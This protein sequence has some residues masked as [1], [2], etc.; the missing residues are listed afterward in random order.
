M[1][2]GENM[3][4]LDTKLTALANAIRTKT[5]VTGALSLDAMANA[6][7]N[8]KNSTT[9]D[10]VSFIQRTIKKIVIS[11]G[12]TSIGSSA[13]SGCSSLTSVTIPSGVTSIGPNAFRSCES[14]TSVTIPI[15]VTSIDFNV[16]MN[17]NSL[18]DI[19][20][21][22]AEGAVSGAPWGAYDEVTIH[23]NT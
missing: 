18:T 11:N 8:Y 10:D 15:S 14:L 23:Y 22:F 6:I 12:V 4:T 13:F 19:Y 17:C 7:T 5:G 3:G 1:G 20:C 2:H 16:F 9:L 21:G